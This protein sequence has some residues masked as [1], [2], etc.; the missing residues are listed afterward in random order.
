MQHAIYDIIRY[1]NDTGVITTNGM[2]AES[3]ALAGLADTGH[4]KE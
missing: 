4:I 3:Q 2:L 1:D